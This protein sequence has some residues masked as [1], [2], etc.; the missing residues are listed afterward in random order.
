M[1]YQGRHRRET[2]LLATDRTCTQP[3]GTAAVLLGQLVGEFETVFGEFL[4]GV[5]VTPVEGL[6][7]LLVG[8]DELPGRECERSWRSAIDVD[9]LAP[10]FRTPGQGRVEDPVMDRVQRHVAIVDE[11]FELGQALQHGFRGRRPLV[12]HDLSR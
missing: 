12:E 9:E 6:H 3:I 10:L 2:I 7:G 5:Q 4:A 8:P 11:R 1:A